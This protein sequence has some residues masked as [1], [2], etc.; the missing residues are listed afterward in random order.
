MRRSRGRDPRAAV[1]QQE[2]PDAISERQRR[3]P[4]PTADDDSPHSSIRLQIGL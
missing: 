2:K 1:K 4:W 3:D